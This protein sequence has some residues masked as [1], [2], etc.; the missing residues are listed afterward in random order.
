MKKLLVF[1]AIIIFLIVI[2]GC[3]GNSDNVSAGDDDSTVVT[4]GDKDTVMDADGDDDLDDESTIFDS[5]KTDENEISDDELTDGEVTELD[6]PVD[7]D[8]ENNSETE[9]DTD[10]DT[11]TCPDTWEGPKPPDCKLWDCKLQPWPTCW[12]CSLKSDVSQNGTSCEYC[13]EQCECIEPPCKCLDGNCIPDGDMDEDGDAE[14]DPEIEQDAEIDMEIDMEVDSEADEDPALTAKRIVIAGDSWSCGIVTPTRAILDERG[15][16]DTEITYS[17]TA[18][19]GSTADEWVHNQDNKLVKLAAALDEEPPAEV[20]L[21]VIGGNDVN[22]SIFNDGFDEMSNSQKENVLD[23]IR[24][25]IRSIVDYA[26]LNRP[27]LSVVLVGYDYFHYLFLQSFYGLGDMYLDEYNLAFV[28]LG[29]RKL[30]IENQVQSCY[31]A[32][33]F[34]VLQYTFGDRPH[35]PFS[36]PL[37]EYPPANVPKPGVAPD[38]TPFPGGLYQIP[39]PL[40]QI[41][42]G[43]HPNDEGFT[44]IMNHVFDQGLQNLLEGK[45]WVVE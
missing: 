39:S 10:K 21:L 44:A 18:V 7:G 29:M 30:G 8:E 32:H 15:F 38:Y 34:G 31:Y 43:I 20:L 25:D 12:V 37:L 41:P 13:D 3:N 23:G 14:V 9:E 28:G 17:N 22:A 33:N 35:P 1:N 45:N 11:E 42:D 16:S 2:S 27:D 36:L 26:L 5:D 40:D 24:D 19:A 4:D 6:K